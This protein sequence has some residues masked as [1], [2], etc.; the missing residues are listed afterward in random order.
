VNAGTSD[1]VGSTPRRPLPALSPE[2]RPFLT[3]GLLGELLITTCSDCGYLTHPPLPVCAAC[4]SRAVAPRP[5]SGRARV[6]AFT[7]NHHPWHPAFPPPYVVA[8]VSLIEQHDV[9]LT[10]NIVGCD[11]DE[12]QIGMSVAVR[13]AVETDDRGEQIALPEFTPTAEVSGV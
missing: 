1:G 8:I 9:H 3:G 13:F 12:V 7:I 4:S 10:T 5:V 6:E 2:T 11:P